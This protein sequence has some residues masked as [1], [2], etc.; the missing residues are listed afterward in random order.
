MIACFQLLS[1]DRRPQIK[2]PFEFHLLFQW[3]NW[4]RDFFKPLDAQGS[5]SISASN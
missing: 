3:N 2:E 5:V 4:D 1:L